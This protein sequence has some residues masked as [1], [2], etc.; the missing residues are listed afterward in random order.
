[1]R[2][3]LLIHGDKLE[4]RNIYK[5]NF[6]AHFSQRYHHDGCSF[7]RDFP[8][9]YRSFL[10]TFAKRRTNFWHSSVEKKGPTLFSREV[11]KTRI[12]TSSGRV[13]YLGFRFVRVVSEYGT[14]HG[15]TV[16]GSCVC[17]PAEVCSV[18]AFPEI[19]PTNNFFS[20]S[21]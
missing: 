11:I 7:S 21:N 20:I 18:F 3:V 16:R 19:P 6:K 13:W 5:Y 14:F 2:F 9:P 15:R 8:I 4:S 12:S 17:I 1:M 10:V